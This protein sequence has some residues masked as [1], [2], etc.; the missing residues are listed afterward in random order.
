M[1]CD[2]ISNKYEASLQNP[3]N[4]ENEMIVFLDSN[5]IRPIKL[6]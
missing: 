2:K 4:V 6:D 3:Q 1:A 5:V